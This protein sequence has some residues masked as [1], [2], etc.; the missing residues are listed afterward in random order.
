[1][2]EELMVLWRPSLSQHIPPFH[3]LT[4][5][6]ALPRT[7]ERPPVRASPH[8]EALRSGHGYPYAVP[9]PPS[10]QRSIPVVRNEHACLTSTRPA[11]VGFL[12]TFSIAIGCTR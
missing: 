8:R 2:A 5:S 7:V 11:S 3:P 1:M 4:K 10:F 12:T 6:G 9:G